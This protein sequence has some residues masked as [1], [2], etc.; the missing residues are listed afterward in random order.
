M[1]IPLEGSWE[2]EFLDDL[3]FIYPE[4][5]TLEGYKKYANLLS[6]RSSTWLDDEKSFLEKWEKK[7]NSL[8][9]KY[10]TFASKMSI[11][12]CL[13]FINYQ[14]W[15]IEKF[16]EREKYPSIYNPGEVIKY[17]LNA[18]H[19]SFN[20][21]C[22]CLAEILNKLPEYF[23]IAKKLIKNPVHEDVELATYRLKGVA[24]LIQ[25]ECLPFLLRSNSKNIAQMVTQRAQNS[26]MEFIH[27][28]NEMPHLGNFCIGKDL[29]EEKYRYEINTGASPYEIYCIAKEL[30]EKTMQKMKKYAKELY[31]KYFPMDSVFV[32]SEAI[33]KLIDILSNHQIL[34]ENFK[35]AI[36]EDIIDLKNFI[37]RKNFFKSLPK[38]P[39]II[40]N[41]PEYL[42]GAGDI[43]ITSPSYFIEGA[44]TYYN[45]RPLDEF[46]PEELKDF[47]REYN[48]YVLKILNIHEVMPGHHIQ[49]LFAKK[50]K[51]PVLFILGNGAFIEGWAV[52]AEHLMIENGYNTPELSFFYQKWFLRI[53]LNAILDYEIHCKQLGEEEAVN[54]LIN[55]G[56]QAPLE[57]RTKY[58]RATL[59][60]VQLSSYL[61]GFLKI[62]ALKESYFN[63]NPSKN[64][65]D[66]HEWL[67]EETGAPPLIYKEEELKN[68]K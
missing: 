2:T 15:K 10:N 54:M 45:V 53:I 34:P 47:L 63:K 3:F 61:A 33:A 32:N 55:E 30:K 62:N 16:K 36:E 22:D 57:A 7:L 59:T 52:Y 68:I 48:I 1:E 24:K 5:G 13:D 26:I 27:F 9:L 8:L 67:L 42:K 40:R 23:E 11:L 41:T 49:G 29:F 58:K 19:F 65:S 64:I 39:L 20:E 56:F 51:H 17:I 12:V 31:S 46:S 14:K 25:D 28:I 37:L 66:F 60:S 38:D 21:K 35:K 50:T 4:K 6:F 44:P 18:N 43:S